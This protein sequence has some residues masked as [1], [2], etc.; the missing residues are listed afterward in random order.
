VGFSIYWF[1]SPEVSQHL[2][3]LHVNLQKSS[4][5][6]I[7]SGGLESFWVA[8]HGDNPEA[9]LALACL[10]MQADSPAV[11]FN[12]WKPKQK[13]FMSFTWLQFTLSLRSKTSSQT[14]EPMSQQNRKMWKFSSRLNERIK[15]P[16]FADK[17]PR[18][19]LLYMLHCLE[20]WNDRNR[21]IHQ[22]KLSFLSW[23]DMLMNLFSKVWDCCLA[24]LDEAT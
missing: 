21:L 14:T 7:I 11:C 12:H 15:A 13:M 10:N 17:M 1:Q 22:F 19:S 6:T 5:W 3:F 4:G 18:M 16:W 8:L 24:T 9:S 20:A 2:S 23:L